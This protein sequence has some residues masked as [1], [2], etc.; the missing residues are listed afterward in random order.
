MRQYTPR[1]KEIL[2]LAHVIA[3][4]M[5]HRYVGTEHIL[6]AMTSMGDNIAATILEKYHV[7][8]EPLET[9]VSQLL[10]PT[11]GTE[12]SFSTDFSPRAEAM[13]QEADMIAGRLSDSV[14]GTEHLFLAILFNEECMAHRVLTKVYSLDVRRLC[15]DT[16]VAMGLNNSVVKDLLELK[17]RAA[18]DDR[19]ESATPTLDEYTRDLTALFRDGK[20][21]PVI[22]RDEEI[23]RVLQV[24]SRRNKNNPCL[25]GLPGVGKT[26]I[27]EGIAA[28][29]VDGSVPEILRGKRILALNLAGMVAGTRYRG[30]FEERIHNLIEEATLA[31]NVILFADEIHTLMGA[32]NAEGTMDAANI[33][34]PA[35]SRGE[36]QMIGATTTEEYRKHIEKDPALER[37]FQPVKVEEPDDGVTLAILQGI[38]PRFEKHHHVKISDEALKACISMSTRYL[39]ER[40]LPDK[41]IDLMDEAASKAKLSV[42]VKPEKIKKLEE[43]LSNLSIQVEELMKHQDVEGIKELKKTMHRKENRL[44]KLTAEW[45]TLRTNEDTVV[46][47]DDIAEV[48]SMLTKIPVNKLAVEESKRLLQLEET[49]HKRIIG[50]EAAVTAI[51]KAMRRGRVGLKDP[52]RPIGSLMFLG[53]TGVGKTELAKALAEAMFGSE[54]ALIRVDMSE[55]ME[56]HSVSKI[57]GSPPGYV[58]FDDGNNMTEK[59]RR[60]PYSVILFDEVEKAHADVFNILLQVLEDGRITDSTGRVVD[61]KNTIIIMTSNAGA[62]SIVEPKSFGFAPRQDAASEHEDM[63]NKV[64]EEVKRIFR[65][66]FLNRI[67]EIVVFHM[68][69]KEHMSQIIDILMNQMNERLQTQAGITVTLSKEAKDFLINSSY[70]VKYGARPLRRAL[71]SKVEDALAEHILEGKVSK[72][73]NICVEVVDQ[74]LQFSNG[75]KNVRKTRK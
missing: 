61:F 47:E 2:D 62:S 30:D 37:R 31:D 1:A 18:Q 67:D 55:Y 21:E 71:Q 35:L 53:P 33:L 69:S 25:I 74:K 49:L 5:K 45:E 32:G 65:P 51:A 4:R 19:K 20:L 58:G 60:N 13:M 40:Y 68:L 46:T 66:E 64:M 12:R 29:I 22:G 54:N 52:K 63:K 39:N 8:A 75:K 27:V 59:V 23:W 43:E 15:L 6:L 36:I 17:N 28:R 9:Y 14:I 72:N 70:D 48:V 24:L 10:S 42:H 50:Q 34:K 16:V 73:D 3:G 41:A 57:I 26:A 7:E 38:R 44:T 11:E 56:K